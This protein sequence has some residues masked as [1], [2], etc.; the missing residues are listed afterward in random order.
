[1]VGVF[2]VYRCLPHD[3]MFH[4]LMG[5]HGDFTLAS[6]ERSPK[7]PSRKD[8]HPNTSIHVRIDIKLYMLSTWLKGNKLVKQTQYW[9]HL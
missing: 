2:F 8:T 1:M 9:S 4:T 3:I 7:N 6:R 5:C